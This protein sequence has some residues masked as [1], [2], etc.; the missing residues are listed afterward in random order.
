MAITLKVTSSGIKEYTEDE[1]YHCDFGPAIIYPWKGGGKFWYVRG[2]YLV[3]EEV[4]IAKKIL[5]GD[6]RLVPLYVNHSQLKYFC[7]FV[8]NR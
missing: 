1:R 2:V 6:L 3:P 7:M 5:A 8:L 4:A